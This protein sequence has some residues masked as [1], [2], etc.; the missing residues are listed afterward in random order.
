MDKRAEKELEVGIV[1]GNCSKSG[2][3]LEA[4]FEMV[5]LGSALIEG[6]HESGDL[7]FYNSDRLFVGCYRVSGYL[8][9]ALRMRVL[10]GG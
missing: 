1:V 9:I 3:Q 6:T 5:P 4:G 2:L 7:L 8:H 10:K